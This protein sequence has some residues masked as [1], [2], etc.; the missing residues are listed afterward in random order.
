MCKS[1]KSLSAV[2]RP[3]CLPPAG[4]TEDTVCVGVARLG[5]DDQKIHTAKLQQLVSCDLG[6]PLHSLVI[7]GQLHPLEVDMLR[8]N[9]K[10]GA[11]EHLHL[12]DSST[13]WS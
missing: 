12:I 8:L 11:L 6:G 1:L 5:A 7:T 13:Y 3:A 4:V 10:P 2:L 9:A